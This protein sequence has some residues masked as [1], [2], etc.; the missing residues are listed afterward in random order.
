MTYNPSTEDRRFVSEGG[1]MK[2]GF[3]FIE[4]LVVIAIGAIM[5]A[6]LIPALSRART[7]AAAATCQDNIHRIGLAISTWRND[8]D[9]ARNGRLET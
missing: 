4:L 5:A 7:A 8:H 9:G 1:K 2:R 3:T 6:L